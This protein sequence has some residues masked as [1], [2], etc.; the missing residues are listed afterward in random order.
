MSLAE[1]LRGEGGLLAAAVAPDAP[2]D[3]DGP[4][5]AVLAAIR[6]GHEQHYGKGSVIRTLPLRV[7]GSCERRRT[8]WRSR[9]EWRRSPSFSHFDFERIGVVCGCNVGQHG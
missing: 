9:G 3:G 5:A 6:E 1:T 7:S 4:Y 8:R 2:G